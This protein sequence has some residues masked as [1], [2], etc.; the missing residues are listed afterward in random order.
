VGFTLPTLKRARLITPQCHVTDPCSGAS[1]GG[2]ILM[3]SPSRT[4]AAFCFYSTLSNV[5]NR[6]LRGV[7]VTEVSVTV[8][9]T[10]GSDEGY[11]QAQPWRLT[12]C[13]YLQS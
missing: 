11:R 4:I 6:S 10:F 3:N 13:R 12:Q 1:R 5:R 7:G 8:P 2:T 9:W